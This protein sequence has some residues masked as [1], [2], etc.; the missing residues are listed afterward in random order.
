M[1]MNRLVTFATS[2]FF[3]VG[4]LLQPALGRCYVE[5]PKEDE[6]KV[7][8]PTSVVESQLLTHWQ[9]QIARIPTAAPVLK[10]DI[11]AHA[12]RRV[13]SV[14]LTS[15]SRTYETISADAIDREAYEKLLLG[16]GN[17]QSLNDLEVPKLGLEGA[18]RLVEKT[19]KQL[20]I[21]KRPFQRF[22][23]DRPMVYLVITTADGTVQALDAETGESIW[24]TSV[25]KST[26]KTI[27]GGT[28]DD[29]VS[30][31]NGSKLYVL[32]LENGKILR[33]HKLSIPAVGSIPTKDWVLVTGIHGATFGYHATSATLKPWSTKNNGHSSNSPVVSFDR[34]FVCWSIEPKY[35]IVTKMDEA[36]PKLWIRYESRD[37]VGAQATPV[38]NGFLV[39]SASGTVARI[40][41][42]HAENPNIRGNAMLWRF[43]TGESMLQPPLFGHG[44]VLSLTTKED[45]IALDV[46][47][48]QSLWQNPVSGIRQIMSINKD[49]AY[50]LDIN[51]L[52]RVIRLTD[53][54][55]AATLRSPGSHV[56]TNTVND[57]MY[58]YDNEGKMTCMREASLLGPSNH[59]EYKEVMTE[60]TY[61]KPAAD[62]TEDTDDESMF[63]D[64]AAGGDPFSDEPAS[65]PSSGGSADPFDDP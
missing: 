2:V 17:N 5:D 7:D 45:L 55:V 30:V 29:F 51:N 35:L 14:T 15:G 16:S 65:K 21:L 22:E 10:I 57:R 23:V 4:I 50:A 24:Q 40:G 49:F 20:T 13:Q 27:A 43:S 47:K 59:A 19:E 9:S 54:S 36:D 25:G 31:V 32:S 42:P 37:R 18:R 38:P 11:W 58:F 28:S 61:S 34:R 26:L 33:E 12:T 60:E 3:L 1:A 63:G 48:G 52:V 64:G 8:Q 62:T 39:C 44:V 6:K 53:G 46:T 56:V 41:L